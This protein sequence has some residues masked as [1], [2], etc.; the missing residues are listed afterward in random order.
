MGLCIV[1]GVLSSGVFKR[2]FYCFW[3]FLFF[4]LSSGAYAGEERVALIIG[5]SE[6]TAVPRLPNP[7]NDAGDLARAL[8]QIGFKVTTKTDLDFQS[9]RLAIQNF[10]ESSSEAEISLVYYAGHGIE[11][12]NTNY[13]IPVNAELKRDVD[14]EFEAIR[15]DAVLGS[16][17]GASGLRV[18]LIDACRNN[19]FGNKMKR[20]LAT[21]SIGRGL[22]RVEPSGVLVGY[23]AKG[24]TIALDGEGRNSPYA[25]A[26]I[27][28]VGKPGLELGKLFRQVRD[29]VL[30]E[31]NGAQ[32]PFVYGSLPVRDI[33]LVPAVQQAPKGDIASA[34]A[35]ASII[36]DFA[37][38]GQRDSIYGWSGFLKKYADQ[39]EHKL[40]K[41]AVQRRQKL[42]DAKDTQ[43]GF[44]SRD[45]WLKP[46]IGADGRSAELSK[47]DKV[48]VQKALNMM[49][50][51]PGPADGQ[52][53]PKTRKAIAQAR[54]RAGLFGS[55]E[56]DVALLR[57]LPNVPEI[58]ALYSD[59]ARLYL[60]KDLPAD[61]EPRLR[62][63]LQRLGNRPL[64]FGYFEGHLY[65]VVNEFQGSFTTASRAA[66][67]AGGHL[68]TISSAR[69]N[70]FVVELFSND[71]RFVQKQPDGALHGP[72]IGLFQADRSNEPA[73]GWVWVTGEPLSYRG[74]S[75]G[76][77]D[78]Y[79][80]RQ[81]WARFYRPPKYSGS[82][83][84]V[85]F[86]DDSSGELWTGGYVVEIE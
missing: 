12:D 81:H 37:K 80:K 10:S 48:L 63:A 53:G 6:Y 75:R 83:V 36:G 54:L 86:W 16:L 2:S 61:L 56:V 70:E 50:F 14:V 15:L 11:I 69:E 9:M 64:L 79:K 73:G 18:V 68:V 82:G 38:A 17:A 49:G 45:P 51:D 3:L 78:N 30:R 29:T 26:L 59:S 19:P 4:V 71:W 20:T 13:L 60:T 47:H 22:A 8:T 21:R 35:D 31:T 7:K 28:H 55:N 74:W 65:L 33:F 76:N 84:K 34:N 62:K 52:F 23:A 58:E 44:A 77:P 66:Q 42:Q 25:K 27:Q 1:E 46:A 67:A 5:N 85:K 39:P 57:V 43:R 24:G 72:M 41:L 40:V 32:E